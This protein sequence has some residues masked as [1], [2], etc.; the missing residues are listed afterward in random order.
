MAK[1]KN[2]SNYLG[3][4]EKFSVRV[5]KDWHKN[6]VAYLM[7][8]PIALFYIIFKYKPMYGILIA[9]KNFSPLKGILD[10]PWASH[11][12]FEHFLSFF[13]SYYFWRLIKNTLVISI[14]T[15]IFGFPAPIILALLI[16]EV[17]HR[18]YKSIVQSLV[19]IPHFISMVVICS[20]VVLFVSSDGFITKFL[21]SIG[22]VD[23]S[24]SMLTNSAY[25][26]P[27]YIISGI[28]QSIGWGSIIYLS[29]LSGVD[30]ELYDAAKIDGANHWKCIVHVTI[31]AILPTIIVMFIL[32]I[33][34]IMSI[35]AEKT[36]LLYNSE[37]YNTA[38]IIS[39]F[40]YR[41]GLL[42]SNW[43]YSAAVGLFNS[44]INFGLVIGANKICKK[45]TDM[46]L[47]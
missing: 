24:V 21:S 5:K 42:E 27:I 34:G 29:A 14:S 19:Y 13:Q 41:K 15:L 45:L 39:S 4:K 9:F 6:K 8:I 32:K 43:S 16:N 26:V 47:W 17:K 7:F 38:D 44:V 12:G 20:M 25:Y 23:G 2:H 3:Q 1:S 28:W 37:I 11:Y 18:K 40:V 46:S 31:P 30:P 33:G 35:G 22:L 36:I 10:S